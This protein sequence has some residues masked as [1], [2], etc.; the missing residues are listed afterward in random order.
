MKKLFSICVV[1]L[2]MFT[3]L[4]ANAQKSKIFGGTVK[5]SVK[6]E[7]NTDPRSHVPRDI[8][9][10]ILGNKTKMVNQQ[11]IQILD[12]DAVT[13]TML[14]DVPGYRVG[15]TITKEQIEEGHS[16]VKYTYTKGEDTKTIC[17]YV[18]TRYDI[19]LYNV[20][21]DEELKFFVYT[22]TEIGENNNINS[23]E[24]PGLTGYPLYKE[25][26]IKGIKT[27]TEATEIKATKV[28][29]VDFLTP[30][31]YKMMP[32]EEFFRLI[33]GGGEE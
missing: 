12:G 31:D 17:G 18:C 1:A 2:S 8:V 13:N 5:F 30:S 28:K 32:S 25:I 22:T 10:T 24:Y 21:E 7:G 27:I 9:Y 20:E 33:F 26:E 14:L 4:T 23:V 3:V 11:F 16:S 6:F 15:S 19:T 29:S